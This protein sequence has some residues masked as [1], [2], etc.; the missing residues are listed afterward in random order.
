MSR[1]Y[2]TQNSRLTQTIR[3]PIKQ[4]IRLPIKHE[5]ETES[6]D[7]VDPQ[8]AEGEETPSDGWAEIDQDGKTVKVYYK[9]GEIQKGVQVIEDKLYFF[10][11]ET[12]ALVDK[13]GWV[14]DSQGNRYY[15]STD[16]TLTTGWFQLSGNKYYFDP[17]TGAVKQS[18]VFTVSGKQYIAS[19]NGSC[20]TKVGWYKLDSDYYYVESTAGSLKSGW[21]SS[22]SKW[23]YLDA[24]DNCRMRANEV[25]KINGTS[26]V[27]KASG[28]C[29]SNSWVKIGSDWYYTN[30]SCAVRTGWLSSGGKWYYLDPNNNGRMMANE[31]FKV[32]GTSY[33]AKASGECPSN[34]W[35]KVGSTW[36]CTNSSCALR[37]GWVSSGATW[38]WLN[39]AGEMATG[40]VEVG[41]K[42]YYLNSSGAMAT[43]WKQLDGTW[44]YLK[45][46]SGEMVK[47][48]F[49]VGS[50]TYYFD[51]P[52]GAM[53][54]NCK[55]V[56]DGV[57]YE[58][59]S[60]GAV[61]QGWV[62]E[63][64]KWYWYQPNGD[65][66]TGWIND[67][68]TWYY[69]EPSSGAMVTG[70]YKIDGK[71]NAFDKYSGAWRTDNSLFINGLSYANSYSSPTNYF[72][73]VD[74][75]NTKVMIY[76]WQGGE[77]MPCKMFSC[78]VGG[79]STRTPKGSFSLIYKTFSFGDNHHTCY[80]G[81]CFLPGDY[82]FHSVLYK[83]GTYN[84]LDPT[85]NSHRSQGCIR[86]EIGNAKW[87]YDYCPLGTRVVVY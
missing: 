11:E 31:V 67:N 44:Y 8:E 20:V 34:S 83:P 65:K 54:A 50:S 9:D 19:S 86:L 70:W 36:Y 30:G 33:V 38:Y 77:W 57:E 22:G 3:L 48:W 23:Y 60:S 59:L 17:E 71:W 26:Y 84:L 73:L 46:S 58:F 79:W 75:S 64:G 85:L 76:Q 7:Q 40:W 16:A 29:P 80:Y 87:I 27:A 18:E 37:T 68:G 72:I 61:K 21:L 41:G 14:N 24:S 47:G 39:S 6:S 63:G 15:V 45:P 49:K 1:L 74:D 35:V 28:E 62:S 69:L 81:S 78:S 12:G 82:L 51:S 32:N 55:K 13:T 25:F 4:T 5:G 52:T 2:L 56:I 42:R 10:D 43:G 66:A 53:L